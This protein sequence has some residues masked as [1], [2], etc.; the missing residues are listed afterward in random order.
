MKM[1]A[2]A[3][4]A[5]I[6]A[7]GGTSFGADAAANSSAASQT[8]A[9][10][11]GVPA[12]GAIKPAEERDVVVQGASPAPNIG[13]LALYVAQKMGYF[14]DEG[15]DVKINYSHGDSAPLQAIGA[16]QAQ[17]MSGT[18]EALIH[19]YERGL[20]GVLFYQTYDKLIF[21]VA[22]LKDGKITKPAE[23]VGKTIG[24]SSIASTCVLIAKVLVSDAG[25]DPAGVKFL[26]VGT[27]QQALG[28]LNSGQVDALC[29]WDAAYS[30][31]E[32]GANKLTLVHWQPASLTHVGDGGYFTSWELIQKQPNMLAHF[33]RA[34]AKA[35]VAIHKNP[36]GA[37]QIYW[38]VNP[39]AK[40]KGSDAQALQTGLEQLQIVGRS[41]DLSG[42]P[43]P[44][45]EASLNAYV[46]TFLAQGVIQKSIP[47]EQIV[48]NAFVPIAKEA[49]GEASK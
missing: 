24:V 21:S 37:L 42:V 13:Y 36:S 7:F 9:W 1:Y 44:V 46:K 18:P 2:V 33:T 10:I 20:R 19:G 27:G 15:L 11:S 14:K 38:E 8:R 45:D 25:A 35:M 30:Q 4:G 34:I 41:L 31:I 40:P 49:A 12:P 6:A 23:L 26:P 29:L 39:S 47:V 32:T 17:I 28:A 16:G 3:I 22:V 43:K 5:A 48:T